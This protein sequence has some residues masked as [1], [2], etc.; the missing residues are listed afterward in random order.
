[1]Y[2]RQNIY[3]TVLTLSVESSK[4]Q[5]ALIGEFTGRMFFGNAV[6]ERAR[7]VEHANSQDRATSLQRVA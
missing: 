3:L 5:A 2:I 7:K 4:I 6:N 1:V